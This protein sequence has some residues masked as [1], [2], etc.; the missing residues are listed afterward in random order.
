VHNI[1]ESEQNLIVALEAD[2]FLIS[3]SDLFSLVLPLL[4]QVKE[5]GSKLCCFVTYP[6]MIY[7]LLVF[8]REGAFQVSLI[9]LIL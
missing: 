3:L 2:F 1:S 6:N 5:D 7:T 9:S 8:T 4:G